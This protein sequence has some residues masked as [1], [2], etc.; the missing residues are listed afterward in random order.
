MTEFEYIMMG[1]MKELLKHIGKV[2]LMEQLKQE[3]N[4]N[5]MDRFIKGLI[6]YEEK[7]EK[8]QENE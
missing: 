6:V 2:H 5:I 8:G 1:C 3:Y 7:N 4:K